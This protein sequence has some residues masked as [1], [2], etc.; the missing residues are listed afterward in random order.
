MDNELRN[1]SGCID[2]TAY[3]ALKNIRREERKCL[4]NLL[5]LTAEKHGYEITSRI[6]LREIKEAEM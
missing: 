4:I 3:D 5:K 2:K 1:T 6:Y